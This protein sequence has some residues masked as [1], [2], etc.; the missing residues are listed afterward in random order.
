MNDLLFLGWYDDAYIK[1]YLNVVIKFGQY[2][3]VMY[4]GIELI[5]FKFP[6]VSGG[7]AIC[8]A[9]VLF[10]KNIDAA[11]TMTYDPDEILRALKQLHIPHIGLP[12]LYRLNPKQLNLV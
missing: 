12:D 6:K 1:D 5:F 7:F 9:L 2:K 8:T 11:T 10:T 3:Y 4:N